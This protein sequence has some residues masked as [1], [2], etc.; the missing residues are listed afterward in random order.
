MAIS[1]EVSFV[2]IDSGDWKWP[3]DNQSVSSSVFQR[4]PIKGAPG[5]ILLVADVC[6]LRL[7]HSRF[8]M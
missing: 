8:A 4:S 5:L 3:L 7:P 2:R 6:F 1:S